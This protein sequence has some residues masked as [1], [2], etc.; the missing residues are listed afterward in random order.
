MMPYVASDRVKSLVLWNAVDLGYAAFHVTRVA[1]DGKLRP[2]ADDVE[3]GRLGKLK[4]FN[5][6]EILLG[7]PFVYSKENIDQFD[8]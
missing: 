6:S 7:D 8:F 4:V 2:G 5:G 1:V 3:A